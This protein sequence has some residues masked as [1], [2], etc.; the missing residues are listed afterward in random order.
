M[1]VKPQ[2]NRLIQLIH[3]ARR[4]LAM[5]KDTYMLM[6]QGMRGLER[7]TSTA[8]LTVPQ[9]E[10]VLEQLK[11]RG[12]KVRPNRQKPRHSKGLPLADDAQSRKIRALWLEL[13]AIGAVRDPSERALAKFVCT[14]VKIEALQWLD[15][16][17]ASQVIENL[18][19]WRQ[20]ISRAQR[21]L[22]ARELD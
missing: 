1:T 5:D 10:A 13:H 8:D 2:R 7:V 9:M 14:M 11:R 3:V 17:Q 4:E 19:Q 12:F 21:A 6:L 18:K 22:E 20:R 15:T 16:R